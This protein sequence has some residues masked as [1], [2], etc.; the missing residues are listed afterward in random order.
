MKM[1][2]LFSLRYHHRSLLQAYDYLL[3]RRYLAA[4]NYGFFIQ[5]IQYEKELKK[6][7]TCHS[8]IETNPW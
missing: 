6:T 2:E 3:D 7:N 1:D 4:P 5:L 8:L